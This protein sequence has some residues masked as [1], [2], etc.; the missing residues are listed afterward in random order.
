VGKTK[1]SDR[2]FTKE[3]QLIHENR[4][5]K[6]QVSALRKELARV[7]LDR[8][9]NLK[10]T[11]ERNYQEDNAQQGQDI[12]EH[13]KQEWKCRDCANGYMEIFIYSKVGNPWYYRVCST[14]PQ[15][16]NRTISQKYDPKQVKGII[17]KS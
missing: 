11:I 9:D 1:R 3:Q 15:C 14:A 8:F 6:R 10:E 16:K 13:L 5:L 7:D 17:K 2:E 4:L 12:L